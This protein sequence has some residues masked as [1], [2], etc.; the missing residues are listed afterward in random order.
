MH[1]LP[2]DEISK[3]TYDVKSQSFHIHGTT[4][5]QREKTVNKGLEITLGGWIYHPGKGFFAAEAHQLLLEREIDKENIP[6]FL[7]EHFHLIKQFLDHYPLHENPI[8][9]Q[10]ALSFDSQWN[11]HVEM[12]LFDPLD[13]REPGTQIFQNWIF[14]PKK[15]FFHIELPYFMKLKLLFPGA[16]FRF[17]N[18]PS[19][20]AQWDRRISNPSF[21]H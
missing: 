11:L 12:Y 15:G 18:L 20:A 4:E 9:P 17:C 13:L 19:C 14:L 6:Q 7:D 16:N 21:Q 10:Y 2:E 8:Q 5:K 1:T 3:I